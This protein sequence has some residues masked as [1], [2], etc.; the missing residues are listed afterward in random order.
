M[1]GEK[2]GQTGEESG[3]WVAELRRRTVFRVA[4]AYVVVAW[5][6]M[7]G[8]EIVFPAFEL[9]NAA[10]RALILVLAGGLPVAVILAWL[11][12][13]TPTGVRL[14]ARFRA[15]PP[16]GEA[17]TG[18]AGRV[19]EIFA[20]GACIP[21]LAFVAVLL[22]S[23]PVDLDET[24]AD[25]APAPHFERI[26]GRSVAVLPFEDLTPGADAQAFFARGIHEDLL[27]RVASLSDV[28]VVART[29]VLAY[30]ARP[31]GLQAMTDDLGIAHVLE[32]TIRR[33]ATLIRVTAQLT[34]TDTGELVWA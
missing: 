26:D 14:A 19:I 31:G 30:L 18:A 7:Q 21:A 8:A 6:L 11:I 32:G 5:V 23:N 12:D 9:S 13:V 10:L 29:T 27:T 3:S 34:G 20:L 28:R 25:D 2:D 17:E 24:E 1:S 33:S 22:I 16:D 15:E 4:A